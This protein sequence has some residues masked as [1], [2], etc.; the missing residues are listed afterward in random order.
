VSFSLRAAFQSDIGRVRSENQDRCLCDEAWGVYGVADGVGGM[1]GGR[2][3]AEIAAASV[4]NAF[5][6]LPAG[7]EPDLAAIVAEAHQRVSQIGQVLNP[8]IG[9]ATTLTFGCR[10]GGQLSIAHVGDSR[11][12]RWHAGQV[13]CLT[14][15]H[16]VE[17]ES[18]RRGE[19]PPAHHGQALARCVGQ[20]PRPEPDLVSRA[21]VGGERY[22]F[23]TDGI[24][25]V[26][27][28]REIGVM[29]GET[30]TPAHLLAKLIALALR[31]GGPDN[32]SGVLVFVDGN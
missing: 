2:E 7:R 11:C 6:A 27:S 12:Y 4:T 19:I 16:S 28:D 21:L 3:A 30:G 10:R 25:R 24:S 13:Q 32:A 26:I 22:L 23:C 20:L 18:R 15:D 9:V 31:R 1:P 17:N 29:L 14:E 5:H 8:G